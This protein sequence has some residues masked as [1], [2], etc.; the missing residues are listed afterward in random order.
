MRVYKRAK[1][2]KIVLVS[3]IS[4]AL[5]GMWLAGCKKD[6]ISPDSLR[7]VSFKVPDGWPQPSYSFADNPLTQAGFELG[8]KL[9]YDVR[10]SRDSSVSCGSCHQQFSAFA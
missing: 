3:V 2:K 5:L 8:R 7:P 10:L 9:F 1:M 6:T 4:A